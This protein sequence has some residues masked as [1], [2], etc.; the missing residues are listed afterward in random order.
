VRLK[1]VGELLVLCFALQNLSWCSE[2]EQVRHALRWSGIE[3]N[4]AAK[5][6]TEE[7]GG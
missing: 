4:G 3:N 5:S 2:D 1:N 7:E 6:W